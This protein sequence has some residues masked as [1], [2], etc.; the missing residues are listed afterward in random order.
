MMETRNIRA[1]I[2]T[3]LGASALAVSGCGTAGKV[4]RIGDDPAK[5]AGPCPEAF[6]LYEASRLVKFEGAESYSNVSYTA[7]INKVRS[8]CRY[9]DDKPIEADL[10]LNISFGR[11]P[12]AQG[13]QATYNYFVAVTRKNIDVIEKKVFP[14]KVTFP[15]GVSVMEATEEVG[16]ILIPRA[17][18]TTSGANFEIIVGFDLTADQIAFNS[19]GKRFRVSAGQN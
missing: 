8:L 4:L 7:E 12:A 9:Y 6:A 17:T 2:L 13:R 19:D 5:N 1:V 10:T 16:K 14:I 15:E 11:G 18:D 3:L